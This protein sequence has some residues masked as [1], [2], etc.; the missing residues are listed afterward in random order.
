MMRN[1]YDSKG[2]KMNINFYIQSEHYY[3]NNVYEK[4]PILTHQS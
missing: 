2:G 4:Y 3:M 1:V